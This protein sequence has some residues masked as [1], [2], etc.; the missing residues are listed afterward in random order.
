MLLEGLTIWLFQLMYDC[1][2]MRGLRCTVNNLGIVVFE[3]VGFHHS[4]LRP[5][6]EIDIMLKKTNAKWVWNCSASVDHCFSK[7]KC[8]EHLIIIFQN[9][10]FYLLLKFFEITYEG[11]RMLQF[12]CSHSGCQPSRCASPRC[13]VWYQLAIPVSFQWFR[14]GWYHPWRLAP[15]LVVHSVPPNLWRTY[16]CERRLKVICQFS[17]KCDHDMRTA[18]SSRIH[19]NSYTCIQ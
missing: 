19:I 14:N 2:S 4:H 15:G 5:V 17:L 3:F 10:S 11:H 9:I 18:T 8:G 13:L 16:T 1:Y 7:R 12:Q 6:R